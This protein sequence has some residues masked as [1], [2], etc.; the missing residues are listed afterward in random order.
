[1]DKIILTEKELEV[2][3]KQLDGKIEVYDATDEE[4]AI[5]MG[6]VDKAEELLDK[7][8]AYDEL[9]GDLIKWFFDKY[10]NQGIA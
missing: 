9:K 10:Q 5:L 4:Q 6:V 1:M 8:D 7:L 3:K 2:I